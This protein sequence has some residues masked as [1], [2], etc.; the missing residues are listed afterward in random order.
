MKLSETLRR[1]DDSGDCGQ[2]LEGLPEL[3]ADLEDKLEAAES[4]QRPA[5][6]TGSHAY[7][8][9]TP[10][11]DIDLVVMV[12]DETRSEL[13]HLAGSNGSIYLNNVNIIALCDPDQ[14]DAWA[15]GTAELCSREKKVTRE[16]AVEVLKACRVLASGY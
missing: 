10:E 1:I 4:N 3:A 8:V 9:P 11:S 16:E 15:K 14:Y 5:F 12:S 13:F 2:Y 7:G 6:L